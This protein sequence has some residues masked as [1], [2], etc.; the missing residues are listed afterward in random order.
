M[1]YGLKFLHS[2][3]S[4]ASVHEA[5]AASSVFIGLS[6]QA[7]GDAAIVGTRRTEA[8]ERCVTAASHQSRN[9]SAIAMQRWPLMAGRCR[10]GGAQRGRHRGCWKT[11]A[12][13]CT[14]VS[15][16]AEPGSWVSRSKVNGS[17]SPDQKGW[18]AFWVAPESRVSP[19][20]AV[21]IKTFSNTPL[22]VLIHRS[23]RVCPTNNHFNA[24][25]LLLTQ[26]S[27]GSVSFQDKCGGLIAIDLL[28]L[29]N[30]PPSGRS[31]D[32][33]S[34]INC[35]D[36]D[37]LSMAERG[38]TQRNVQDVIFKWVLRLALITTLLDLS[39]MKV[40]FSSFPE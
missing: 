38:A 23:Q 40:I 12:F 13:V 7:E 9:I 24:L 20:A 2:C 11:F 14:G 26:L 25:A 8:C 10:S 16:A 15:A 21:T 28:S 37:G 5:A 31:R 19:S 33:L 22:R 29:L 17:E 35:R 4:R 6:R 1:K 32:C 27:C 34:W 18:V 36:E 30:G 39:L 3:S